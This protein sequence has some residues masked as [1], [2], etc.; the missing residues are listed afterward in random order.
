MI[1]K[2]IT[3]SFKQYDSLDELT[4]EQRK[5]LDEAYKAMS[6][7]YAPYSNFHVGASLM[8]QD[9]NIFIGAN[10]ENA[11]FPMCICAEGSLLASYSSSGAKS[12]I[13]QVAVTAS[14]ANQLLDS[15][16]AP[17]GACRQMLSEFENK[18]GSP[19]A[20]ILKGSSGPIHVMNSVKD[21]LPFGFSSESL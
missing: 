11:A 18:Q 1:D 16:V 20:I 12:P 9:G 21:I 4:A 10:M 8:D 3:I 13:V 19:I 17:C 2:N 5:L 15:P 7:A 14:S 6:N